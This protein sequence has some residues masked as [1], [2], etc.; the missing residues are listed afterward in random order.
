[1]IHNFAGYRTDTCSIIADEIKAL[2]FKKIINDFNNTELTESVLFIDK[3]SVAYFDEEV[4]FTKK[5]QQFVSSRN[6]PDDIRKNIFFEICESVFTE[7]NLE[8]RLS[9]KYQSPYH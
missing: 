2:V 1:M 8:E 9:L 4:D 6:P 7:Y 5:L 3:S